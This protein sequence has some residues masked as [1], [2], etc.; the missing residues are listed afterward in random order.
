MIDLSFYELG[1]ADT[2]REASEASQA[3]AKTE[4]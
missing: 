4:R 2:T 3:D 1:R